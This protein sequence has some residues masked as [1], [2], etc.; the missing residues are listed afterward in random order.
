MVAG[1]VATKITPEERNDSKEN[2]T[3]VARFL[4]HRKADCWELNGESGKQANDTGLAKHV[5]W[6]LRLLTKKSGLVFLW[7][8]ILK[9]KQMVKA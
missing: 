5:K 2:A 9:W 4:G 6:G 1:M 7:D 3:T 8:Q